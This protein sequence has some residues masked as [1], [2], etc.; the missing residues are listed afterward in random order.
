MPKRRKHF[1]H[2]SFSAQCDSHFKSL[3]SFLATDGVSDFEEQLESGIFNISRPTCT[4]SLRAKPR[5]REQAVLLDDR[6]VAR[7]DSETQATSEVRDG[8]SFL[9]SE[10]YATGKA[11]PALFVSRQR[12]S[13]GAVHGDDFYVLANR[14]AID[15]VGTVW[16]SKYKVGDTHRVGFEKHCTRVVV[17]LNRIVVLG[18]SEGRRFDQI[19]PDIRHVELIFMSLGLLKSSNAVSTPRTRHTDTKLN[20]GREKHSS[21]QRWPQCFEPQCFDPA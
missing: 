17:A 3:L 14:V 18:A 19:E 20:D 15:H 11:N 5:H 12:N 6:T 10:G 4:A 7:T 13:R 2:T 16:S 9:Q 21:L 1:L 8:Q